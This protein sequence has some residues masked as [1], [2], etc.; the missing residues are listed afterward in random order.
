[1]LFDK[2]SEIVMKA[3]RLSDNYYGIL[4]H[5]TKCTLYELL[6]DCSHDNADGIDDILWET[7]YEHCTTTNNLP[8]LRNEIKLIDE[9]KEIHIIRID[10]EKVKKND[11]IITKF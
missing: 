10:D 8:P 11:P 4:S 1:M 2:S 6:K 5:G 7:Q 3:Q 9:E